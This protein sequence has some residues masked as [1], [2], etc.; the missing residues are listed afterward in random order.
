MYCDID[1]VGSRASAE[2]ARQTPA[3]PINN[4]PRSLRPWILGSRKVFELLNHNLGWTRHG[5][6]GVMIIIE[7]YVHRLRGRNWNASCEYVLAYGLCSRIRNCAAY[8]LERGNTRFTSQ[9]VGERARWHGKASHVLRNVVG[10]DH[11]LSVLSVW[12][13]P[14]AQFNVHLA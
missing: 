8:R 2:T 14:A 1:L 12:I 13:A 5:I 10:L 11:V 9:C 7:I 6:R 3:N 4:S